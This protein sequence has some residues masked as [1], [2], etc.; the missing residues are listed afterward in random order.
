MNISV[1]VALNKDWNKTKTTFSPSAPPF[2]PFP[3]PFYLLSYRIETNCYALESEV[4]FVF[5]FSLNHSYWE[6][7]NMMNLL[8]V[9]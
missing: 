2:F 8:H 3:D 9:R 5:F 7:I 1:F 4:V 6:Q